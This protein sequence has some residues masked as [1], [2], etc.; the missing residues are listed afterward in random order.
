MEQ[1]PSSLLWLTA[2]LAF[3]IGLAAGALLCYLLLPGR[4]KRSD[5]ELER[6]QQEFNNYKNQVDDHFC[7]SALLTNKLT[8]S[9]KAIHEHLATSASTLCADDTTRQRLNDAL[10][11]SQTLVGASPEPS[12]HE[13]RVAQEPPRDYAAPQKTESA[14]K[15]DECFSQ[16]TAQDETAPPVDKR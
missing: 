9:Y 11:S 1:D 6:V 10:L 8:E 15:E 5:Q 4:S 2:S 12:D 3:A 7:T 14:A 16:E 13:I